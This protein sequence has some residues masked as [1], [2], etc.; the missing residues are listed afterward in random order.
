[1]PKK[2]LPDQL[3]DPDRF[4]H[5]EHLK[6][7]LKGRSIRS[8]AVTMTAQVGKFVLNFGSTAVLARLLTPED[9]GL[10][11]MVIVVTGFIELFNEMG[12]STA[13]V[14]KAEITHK[15]V[16]T[17]F[18]INVGIG[19]LLMMATA[20]IAPGVAWF[21]SEPRL[22]AITVV[23]GMG[24][25]LGG[26]GVQ[27]QALLKRQM[28]FTSLAMIEI[29]SIIVGICTAIVSAW[30][31]AGYW[32]LVFMP[33]A[34]AFTFTVGVWIMCAWRPG[35]PV[36]KS[37]IGSMLA[38]GGH[39][40]GQNVLN[41]FI[42]NLDNLLIGYFLG[43]QALGLY[44]KAYQLL[45]LP[46]QQINGPVSNVAL[47]TLS[48][49][50]NEPERYREYYRKGILLLVVLGM[51]LIAFLVEAADQVILIVLGSRWTDAIP[52][53]RILAP[54]AFVGTFNVATGWVYT[55][56]G[57][58]D[59]QLRWGFIASAVTVIG[60]LIGIQWGTIGI[61]AS[62]SLTMCLLRY[63][64]IVYCFKT[65]PLKV[66]DLT[67][68]LWRPTVASLAAAA[69]LFAG[70]GWLALGENLLLGLLIKGLVYTLLYILIWCMLPN[71]WQTLKEILRLLKELR[72]KPKEAVNGNKSP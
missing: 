66:S 59:R 56:L 5:T 67:E 49:L 58:A 69:I 44:A 24:F 71:G 60:F 4:L 70:R 52:L 9:Y 57:Q 31:G 61:A 28:R 32:A 48:R 3:N 2:D 55:S 53:F 42:R 30:Q 7:D 1:M 33:L 51:P 45:L 10:I 54:A 46:I 20:A 39:I 40:T 19:W 38:F 36:R 37:G 72:P 26:L 25:V 22:T 65:T 41:Y 50:Q 35:L 23:L 62:V 27:H 29:G 63:P 43:P 18:W 12:L 21:Y 16:S 15:Q 17:L 13:T 34:R 47:P 64:G 8:G 11:G 6:A 68:V 14:Q